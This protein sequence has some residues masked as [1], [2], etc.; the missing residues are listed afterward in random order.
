MLSLG[1]EKKKRCFPW[2]WALDLRDPGIMIYS[3]IIPI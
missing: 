1:Q 3:C 2:P